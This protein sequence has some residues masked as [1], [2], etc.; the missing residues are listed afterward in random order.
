MLTRGEWS[1]MAMY[2]RPRSLGGGD[3]LAQPGLAVAGGGVHVQ[4]A[5]EVGRPR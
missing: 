2:L 3:H 1:V 5:D 4:V